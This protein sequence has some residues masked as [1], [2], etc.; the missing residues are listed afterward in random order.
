[1]NSEIFKTVDEL[2]D[3]YIDVW[4][5]VCNI[6]SPTEYKAGVDAVGNLFAEM[7]QNRGWKVEYFN[8]PV[9]GNVVCITMNPDVDAPPLSLSGHMDTVYPIGSFGKTPVCRDEEKIYG[10]G[11]TDC[12]GGIVAAFLAM[13]A[14]YQC[15]FKALPIQLLL[16]SD[17]E[18]S[19]YRSNK[20]TIKY[21]CKKAKNSVAFIN[22]EGYAAGEACIQR[23]GIITFLFK[24]TGAEAHA[25][26][27]AIL[28][29]NAIAEAAHK[30]LE[31][32]KI[33]D[34]SGI[35]CCCS[36]I[37][38]GTTPNTVPGYCEFKVNVRFATNEQYVWIKEEMQRI[39]DNVFISGCSTALHVLSE[40]VAMELTKKNS[41]LLELI[42]RSFKENGLPVLEK[43]M[44]KGGSDAA[45][46]T[47][48]GIP[49]VDG[50]GVYGGYIH[51]KDEYAYID[52]LAE[53]AKRI[54]SIA[55]YISRN[56]NL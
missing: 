28:G 13:D 38:G 37:S 18:N 42:N 2:S 19:S 6:E 43:A 14:L 4:E 56:I 40:R 11:V 46:V 55:E 39:A 45:D 33:K 17:E 34:D 36:V 53:A 10:P 7:A 49:C 27:C 5:K 32:E 8:Q 47:T 20:A 1:M 31:I 21:I 50:L 52:S 30:I 3:Y 23:K 26:N 54:V 44:R 48:Y 22:L 25:S 51:S 41:D 15:G 29:A 16:Q 35:T 9:S 12:K 24:I